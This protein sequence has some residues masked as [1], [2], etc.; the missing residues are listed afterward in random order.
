M[1]DV[2]P[3]HLTAVV[4]QV[5]HDAQIRSTRVWFDVFC[6]D[7]RDPFHFVANNAFLLLQVRAA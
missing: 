2:S 7:D 4:A 1:D 3:S 6:E 5:E